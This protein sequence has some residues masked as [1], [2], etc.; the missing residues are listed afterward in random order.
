MQPLTLGVLVFARAAG[1]T[2]AAPGF[3][4]SEVPLKVR[5][6]LAAILVPV[7]SPVAQAHV[8]AGSVALEH[9]PVFAAKEAAVGLAL[10]FAAS[11]LFHGI[12]MAGQLVGSQIGFLSAAHGL[13]APIGGSRPSLGSGAPIARLYYLLGILTYFMIDGHH[14]LLAAAARAYARLPVDAMLPRAGA[15]E[16]LT[17][18]AADMFVVALQV[19]APALAALFFT[20]IVLAMAG[21]AIPALSPFTVWLPARCLV[22]LVAVALSAPLIGAA[23][24]GY[25]QRLHRALL[26]LAS[27]L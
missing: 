26:E 18:L 8:A 22:G 12:G 14:S 16:P 3:G 25:A 24:V 1:M 4:L 19:S 5:F 9:L 10:G 2:A 17:G 7:M 23:V 13:P 20:D 11:L 21:R 6:A 15:G 27:A